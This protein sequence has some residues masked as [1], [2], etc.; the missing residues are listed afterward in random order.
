MI[1]VFGFTFIIHLAILLIAGGG[2]RIMQAPFAAFLGLTMT[3]MIV[4][5]IVLFARSLL[6]DGSNKDFILPLFEECRSA[7]V[8]PARGVKKAVIRID[9]VQ[10]FAGRDVVQK[11]VDD[12]GIRG[13]KPVLAVIPRDLAADKKLVAYLQRNL[14]ATEIALHGWENPPAYPEFLYLDEAGAQERIQTGQEVLAGELGIRASTFVP[15]GNEYSRATAR[16]LVSLGFSAVSSGG[17]G[18][19]D[20]DAATYDFPQQRFGTVDRV[21]EDCNRAWQKKNFCVVMIHPQDFLTDGVFDTRKYRHYVSLLDT[22]QGL[23]VASATFADLAS[24]TENQYP[25]TYGTFR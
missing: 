8:P 7:F 11:L 15:P 10:A 20:F 9:D 23:G 24:L 1:P 18:L 17:G 3:A 2:R 14:C 21:L 16:V 25:A 19:F 13:I 6:A 22:F 12:A 5:G 4:G